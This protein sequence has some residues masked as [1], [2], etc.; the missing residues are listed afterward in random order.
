MNPIEG[1]RINNNPKGKRTIPFAGSRYPFDTY[2][3]AL[4]VENLKVGL[5]QYVW[6]THAIIPITVSDENVK[7]LIRRF[8]KS[9]I[10]IIWGVVPY[11]CEWSYAELS[12]KLCAL[13]V[14]HMEQNGYLAAEALGLGCCV[15]GAYL[16]IDIDRLIGVD[17]VDEFTC[18]IKTFM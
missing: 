10:D 16:Q 15:I 5:Y 9:T 1:G 12:H 11:R 8:D 7:E 14:G 3:L 17:G 13:D 4:S 18:Y 6:S 2:F